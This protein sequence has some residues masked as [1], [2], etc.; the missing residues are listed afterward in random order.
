MSFKLPDEHR[1]LG[2]VSLGFSGT[3]CGLDEV[4]L[5]S[6]GLSSCCCI[7]KDNSPIAR[8]GGLQTAQQLVW[9]S[10][11]SLQKPTA[12]GPYFFFIKGSPR[13]PVPNHFLS[14]YERINVG[15]CSR[16]PLSWVS[17]CR[18]SFPGSG[19]VGRDIW[20]LPELTRN[21]RSPQ[22]A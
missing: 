9:P 1:W 13:S 11:T 21:T 22:F 20:Q 16:Q 15:Y 4:A 6:G 17:I 12:S 8:L 14:F 7:I 2:L 18:P 19:K 10:Q 5:T 3:H